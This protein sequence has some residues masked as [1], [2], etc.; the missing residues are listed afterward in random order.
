MKKKTFYI[1]MMLTLTLD[2]SNSTING[3]P[4]AEQVEKPAAPSRLWRHITYAA[5][6]VIC[7]VTGCI[8]VSESSGSPAK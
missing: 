6:S 4:P 2:A 1:L 7:L 8:V 3:A 5:F